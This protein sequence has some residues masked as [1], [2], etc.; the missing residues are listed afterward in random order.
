MAEKSYPFSADNVTTGASKAVSELDWQ[1]MAIMWGGDRVDYELG[2]GSQTASALPFHA[3]VNNVT[4]VR[5]RAGKAWVGGFKYENT[6]NLDLAVAA[7][8]ANTGRV[9]LVVIRAD[10]SKPAVNLAVRQGV[11]AATPVAPAPVRVA[12][13]IWEMPLWEISVPANGGTITLSSRSPYTLPPS[14][15]FPWNASQ[16]AALMPPGTFSYDVD[17]NQDG[18]RA[19]RFNDKNGVIIS[20]HMGPNITYT[21]ALLNDSNLPSTG[22]TYVGRWRWIAPGTVSFRCQIYNNNVDMSADTG[23]TYGIRLPVP[24]SSTA[25]QVLSGI[26][27]NAA[28]SAGY[29]TF[30][31]LTGFTGGSGDHSFFT[32]YF[33]SNVAAANGLDNFHNFP[34]K[35]TIYFSG[36]YETNTFDEWQVVSG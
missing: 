22:I 19:E 29:P 36:V 12:G 18:I 6:S 9:D 15:A 16:S 23:K 26:L 32:V 24:A 13:G 17:S 2:Y 14:V 8:S 35:S 5:V 33:P 20:R 3:T 10:M 1:S 21:P 25:R 34:S 7:N 11:N 28:G 27:Q 4:S 30:T 31:T